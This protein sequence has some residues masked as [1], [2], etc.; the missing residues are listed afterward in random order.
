MSFPIVKPGPTPSRRRKRPAIAYTRVSTQEQARSGVG[1]EG[2]LVAIREYASRSGFDIVNSFHDSFTG[3]G[4]LNLRKRRGLRRA[5]DEAKR[6]G[7]VIVVHDASRLSRD[8]ATLLSLCADEEL[9]LISATEGALVTTPEQ[10]AIVARAQHDRE[11]ISSQ[12][13][14]ALA[15]LK[16]SGVQLGNRRN[17]P[18]AQKKGAQ[19]NEERGERVARAIADVL[20]DL[21]SELTAREIVDVLNERGVLT[22]R[23]QLFTVA[24]V[25]RPLKRAREIL[26]ERRKSVYADHPLFGLF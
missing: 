4:P 24:A 8:S 26:D 1:S 20:S 22:G 13:K 5:I 6:L 10:A 14:Q 16:A 25:R 18:A 9:E 3:A 17:L 23:G 19:A 11:A 7:G 2:Q 12:T 21:G 15:E